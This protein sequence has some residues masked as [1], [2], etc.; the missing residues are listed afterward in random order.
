MIID[1][2]DKQSFADVSKNCSSQLLTE[3][4][5]YVVA[6]HCCK[7]FEDDYNQYGIKPLLIS[8]RIDFVKDALR[9]HGLSSSDLEH[10]ENRVRS[11]LTNGQVEGREGK[12]SFCLNKK[13]FEDDGCDYFFKYFGGE[14]M[15]RAFEGETNCKILKSL[16]EIGYPLI[17]SCKLNFSE[18]EQFSQ[19]NIVNFINGSSQSCE[20]SVT[21]PVKP[22]QIT[23]I[24]RYS[25]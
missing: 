2:D 5:A 19:D 25:K 1:L 6:H 12:V 23:G 8:E 22:D 21:V 17:I 18:I 7:G 14:A 20:A 3:H 4:D 11:Y 15:Y 16:T 9:L 24:K 13:L 10:F